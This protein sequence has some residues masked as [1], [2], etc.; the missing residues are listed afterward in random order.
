MV[1]NSEQ[2]YEACFAACF[3]SAIMNVARHSHPPVN[4]VMVDSPV[5]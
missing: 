4:Q 1:T 2:L 5:G 3:G